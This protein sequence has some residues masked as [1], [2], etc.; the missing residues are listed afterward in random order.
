MRRVCFLF[1]IGVLLAAIFSVALPPETLSQEADQSKDRSA[2]AGAAGLAASEATVQAIEDAYNRQLL[3]LEQERLVQL[4]RLAARQPAAE[5]AATYERLF[6]LAI[7]GDLFRDAEAAAVKVVGEGTPSPTTDALAHLVKIIAEVERGA[8]EQSLRS[9]RKSI[10]EST[11]EKRATELRAAL[12][13]AEVIGICEAYYQ[14]LVEANQFAIAREAFRLALEQPYSSAVKD[15]LA[16]RLKR[17][18]LVGKPAP[19]IKGTDL[20]GKPFD[21]DAER[22]NVVL[23]VFWASWNLPG[24]AQIAWV[25]QVEEAHRKRG[26][27]VLTINLDAHQGSGQKLET[28][29][30]NIRRFLL[31]YNI[32]WPTLVNGSGDRDVA[33]AYGISDIPA[34]V[35]IGRD[36]SVVQIDLSRRNLEAVISKQL[37]E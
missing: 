32:T 2:R 11:Q 15:F 23:V 36:G 19:P 25:E 30:P 24:A 1:T 35:L 14:R 5:A 26:L 6:R 18:E 3:H 13:P 21:L 16:S 27:R 17:I 31:D 34:N 37:G 9:L 8:F 7:A 10:A 4:G 22:G 29:L 28:V 12:A 33:K 20:D